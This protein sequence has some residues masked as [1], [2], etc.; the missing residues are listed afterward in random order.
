MGSAKHKRKRLI[1]YSNKETEKGRAVHH[2]HTILII[3]IAIF[4][5]NIFL[6]F[7]SA[8]GFFDMFLLCFFYQEKSKV[9]GRTKWHQHLK[10]KETRYT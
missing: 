6:H 9:K 3:V 2:F 1:V 5:Y 4:S 10:R 7:E 8:F